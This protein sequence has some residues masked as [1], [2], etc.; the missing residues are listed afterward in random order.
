VRSPTCVGIV[1]AKFLLGF[2]ISN[3]FNQVKTAIELGIVA[4]IENLF[5]GTLIPT[6]W[7][8]ESQVIILGVQQEQFEEVDPVQDK[9][10]QPEILEVEKKK[11]KRE[12]KIGDI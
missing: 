11:K 6:I 10:F 5:P 12:N 4:G 7:S 1:P 2:K 9:K 8:F 3:D